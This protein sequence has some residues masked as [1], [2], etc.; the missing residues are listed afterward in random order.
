M[1]DLANEADQFLFRFPVFVCIR[2][3][4]G[5]DPY[6][7][8]YPTQEGEKV[9]IAFTD[10]DLASKHMNAVGDQDVAEVIGRSRTEFVTLLRNMQAHGAGLVGFDPEGGQSRVVKRIQDVVDQLKE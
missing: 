5:S 2:K 4:S 7:K 6:L 1:T 3:G 10:D 9:I 8:I